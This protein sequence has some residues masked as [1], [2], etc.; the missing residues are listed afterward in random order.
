MGEI[1]SVNGL[2]PENIYY[3]GV[4]A[5]SVWQNGEMVWEKKISYD[6]IFTLED[7]T[8]ASSTWDTISQSQKSQGYNEFY[9]GIPHNRNYNSVNLRLNAEVNTGGHIRWGLSKGA[10]GSVFGPDV[11]EGDDWLVGFK[12]TSDDSTTAA[13]T[14]DP[15]SWNEPYIP[16]FN[17]YVVGRVNY[18]LSKIDE[19]SE[20]DVVKMTVPCVETRAGNAAYNIVGSITSANGVKESPV[21]TTCVR[22]SVLDGKLISH[23]FGERWYYFGVVG[24]R[25]RAFVRGKFGPEEDLIIP[26]P[27]VDENA[28]DTPL[29]WNVVFS[30]DNSN[31]YTSLNQS[32]LYGF[33]IR[34]GCKNISL[35]AGESVKEFL[36]SHGLIKDGVCASSEIVAARSTGNSDTTVNFNESVPNVDALTVDKILM[37]GRSA[38]SNGNSDALIGRGYGARGYASHINCMLSKSNVGGT[39]PSFDVTAGGRVGT[40]PRSVGNISTFKIGDESFD[41]PTAPKAS[42]SRYDDSSYAF[43]DR[44][45][46]E[47]TLIQSFPMGLPEESRMI[48]MDL[49]RGVPYGYGGEGGQNSSRRQCGGGEAVALV[50]G[51]YL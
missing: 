18:S 45:L 29:P 46:G 5:D 8:P 32:D 19:L 3:N 17:L 20:K 6:S 14:T 38:G 1:Y 22:Q 50:M 10:S 49:Y 37:A 31:E 23:G 51:W 30:M 39:L 12:L 2:V 24:G 15:E 43:P 33:Q 27:G 34:S 16:Q 47:S 40:S 44:S 25:L 4:D 42:S 48:D 36:D 11:S 13:K 7:Y 9:A 35:M 26:V 28:E 41:L 21:L